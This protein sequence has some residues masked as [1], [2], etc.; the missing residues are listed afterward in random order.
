[1]LTFF[2]LLAMYEALAFG[3]LSSPE[4]PPKQSHALNLVRLAT[5]DGMT[6]YQAS[7]FNSITKMRSSVDQKMKLLNENRYDVSSKT[8]VLTLATD[9]MNMQAMETQLLQSLQDSAQKKRS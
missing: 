5:P 1:M 6:P 9:I 3:Q 2:K 4:G 8:A 7:M